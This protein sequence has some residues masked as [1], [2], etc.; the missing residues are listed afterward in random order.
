MARKS[1]PSVQP[2]MARDWLRRYE[3]E[4][5]SPPQIATAD[6]YDVRTVRTHI[7]R[8][9]QKR[10]AK[11]ARSMVLRK[12]LEEHYADMCGLAKRLASEISS[13][14]GKLWAVKN[15]HMYSALQEHLP[16][17]IIWKTIE[18]WEITQ[19]EIGKLKTGIEKLLRQ[20]ITA[21]P[22]PEVETG[23][24]IVIPDMERLLVPLFHARLLIKREGGNLKSEEFALTD[25]DDGSTIIELESHLIGR[26][27]SGQMLEVLER[28]TEILNKVI[29]TEEYQAFQRLLAEREDF[30][31]IL[32]D[33]LAVITFRRVV[34]G[35][36]RYCPV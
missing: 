17:S 26:I 27:P 35:R 4:G 36:C 10:E 30:I 1:K 8:E 31:R 21:T 7:E 19:E 32:Q 11:E 13:D 2:R 20:S 33:E 15:S 28:V 29:A 9:H 23:E 12:A 5:E 22:L 25:N 24:K 3:E 18:Q 6:G 14:E 16:R 34:P